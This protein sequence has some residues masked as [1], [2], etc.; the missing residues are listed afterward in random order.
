MSDSSGKTV[1]TLAV[2]EKRPQRPGGCVG[3]FFQLFDWNRRLAKKKLF[4]RKLLPPVRT[5]RIS[6]KFDGDEKLPA[7]KLLLI[8]DENR[9]GFPNAKKT[10]VNSRCPS[11]DSERNNGMQAPGL[12]ARLMGLESVPAVRRDK[13]KKPSVSEFCSDQGGKSMK[14]VDNL[15]RT[16]DLYYYDQDSSSEKGQAKGDSRPQKLQ[17]TGFFD[18]RPV[19]KFGAEALQ[20]RNVL[21]RSKKQHHHKFS[22]PVKSPRILSTRNAARLMEAAT[23]ILEPGLQATNRA[24]CSLTYPGSRRLSMEGQASIEGSESSFVNHPGQPIFPFDAKSLIVQ[25][26]CSNCGNVLDAMDFR[27]RIDTRDPDFSSSTSDFSNASSHD[28]G[29]S[30]MELCDLSNEQEKDT[31][32]MTSVFVKDQEEALP[33][34]QAKANVHRRTPNSLNKKLPHIP[35]DQDCYKP[36]TKCKSQ[37]P[38]PVKALKQNNQKQNG[39]RGIKDEVPQKPKWSNRQIRNDVA[40]N[41]CGQAKDF[42]SLNRSISNISTRPRLPKNVT[43]NC[44][45]DM[46]RTMCSKKDSTRVK[47]LARKRRPITSTPMAESIGSINSGYGKQRNVRNDASNRNGVGFNTRNVSR[48]CVKTGPPKLVEG[49]SSSSSKDSDIVSFAFSSPIRHA[50][51]GEMSGCPVKMDKKKVRSVLPCSTSNHGNLMMEAKDGCSLS[52]KASESKVD[53]LG[54]LLEEKLR[55][56]TSSDCDEL[57][58][59]DSHARRSTASIL[60]ELISALSML[61]PTAHGNEDKC[62][63]E[64]RSNDGLCDGSSDHGHGKVPDPDRKSKIETEVTLSNRLGVAQDCDHPSPTSILEASFSNDSCFSGSLDGSGRKLYESS[65][66]GSLDTTQ[67]Y[68]DTELSDFATSM[69]AGISKS[70]KVVGLAQYQVFGDHSI[71]SAETGPIGSKINTA[72]E[73]ML[74]A[75]LLFENLAVIDA[76]DMSDSVTEALAYD[77]WKNCKCGKG[78]VELKEE[79]LLKRFLFDFIIEYLDLKYSQYWNLGF[80]AWSKLP[81]SLSRDTLVKQVHEEM[82]QWGHFGGKIVDDILEKEMSCS[83]QKWVNFETEAFEAGREIERNILQVLLDEVVV[84]L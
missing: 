58:M 44:R 49:K 22:S 63:V 81:L 25:P 5:K 10:D 16:Q 38:N 47:T 42:V 24:K 40:A 50:N 69:G 13:P 12:V 51:G 19:S 43:D 29:K 59:G 80:R 83:S 73:V 61:R 46:E 27:P 15:A 31:D 53:A 75:E 76:D 36:N 45:M 18:R 37:K 35:G 2:A 66:H 17:K 21:S 64:L 52:L 9:G 62:V 78:F 28:S 70:E 55:E 84:D 30:K 34:T 3:I 41:A 20:L 11:N 79:A 7:T 71:D 60:Q 67:A 56:L 74:C 68:Q 57:E 6:K 77:L 32:N 14:Q 8:A 72:Q 39:I 26:S 33:L 1:T 65:I 54:A 48:S 23:K 82:G 4:S